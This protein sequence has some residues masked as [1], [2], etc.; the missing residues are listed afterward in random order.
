MLTPYNLF[1]FNSVVMPAM[2][3]T[4]PSNG[5]CIWSCTLY[6]S[7]T[8]SI[9]VH[10]KCLRNHRCWFKW[11]QT[12]FRIRQRHVDMFIIKLKSERQK[13]QQKRSPHNA[14]YMP[15]LCMRSP[16]VRAKC[17]YGFDGSVRRWLSQSLYDIIS[18]FQCIHLHS[19]A[20]WFSVWG[21]CFLLFFF[22]FFFLRFRS[23][24][25]CSEHYSTRFELDKY[26]Y[27]LYYIRIR[28]LDM[29]K[30]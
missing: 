22:L 4:L 11:N 26:S 21:W 1:C 12:P 25:N 2:E 7:T 16:S 20:E 8:T 29:W 5:D 15:P 9:R 13:H 10:W 27:I 28:V 6:M 3:W 24:L 19:A 17:V 30:E 23:A 14:V 18:W